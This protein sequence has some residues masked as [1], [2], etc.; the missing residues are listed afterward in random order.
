MPWP[1]AA[2]E[3]LVY[4]TVRRRR[5][6]TKPSLRKRKQDGERGQGGVDRLLEPRMLKFID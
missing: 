6:L 3:P 4:N 1:P 5:F 2:A